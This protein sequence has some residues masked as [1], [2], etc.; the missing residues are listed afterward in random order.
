MAGYEGKK[1]GSS[2]RL[3]Q[4]ILNAGYVMERD[5]AEQLLATEFDTSPATVNRMLTEDH[6]PS[7]GNL[8]YRIAK[9]LNFSPAYWEYGID[10]YSEELFANSRDATWS[11]LLLRLKERSYK[12][13]DI[14]VGL[15]VQMARLIYRTGRDEE[16][17]IKP[18]Y[19]DEVI[20]LSVLVTSSPDQKPS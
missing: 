3:R 15:M 18:E 7:S 4:A 13:N 19:V 1:S 20:D 9:R 14:P 11:A 2:D 5:N 6:V 10:T 8:K 17:N 12:L 16:G